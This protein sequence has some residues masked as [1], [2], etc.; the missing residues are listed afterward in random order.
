MFFAA[1]ADCLRDLLGT[2]RPRQPLPVPGP[3]RPP[4]DVQT[5][6]DDLAQP[7]LQL[8]K[9]SDAS[10]SYLGG[11]PQLPANLPWPQCDGRRLDFLARLSLAD[12]QAALPLDWLPGEG[13][14]LF[15]VDADNEQ[16]GDVTDGPESWRVLLVPDQPPSLAPNV[17]AG[18]AR[19][20][21]FNVAYQR[22]QTYPSRTSSAVRELRLNEAE[23]DALE[24]LRSAQPAARAQ[25]QVGGYPAP[26]QDDVM[27]EECQI[28]APAG[29]A[30]WRLLL[31]FDSDDDLTVMWGD[32]G[33]LYF[34]VR[35]D[36]GRCGEFKHAWLVAQY[37]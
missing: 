20:P 1:L 31:Q 10:R 23:E 3:P 24:E 21:R 30:T 17:A 14:L 29:P 9:V 32:T 36:D 15:F 7:A 18:D 19:L 28:A 12:M 26:I 27:E 33:M 11:D 6:V 25:H 2:K 4:R 35:A 13:A 37:C 16:L 34:W 22:L 8:V 5:L